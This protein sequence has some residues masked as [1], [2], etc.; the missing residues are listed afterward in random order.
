MKNKGLETWLY[1][2]LGVAAMFG[3]IVIVNALAS[4]FNKRVDLTAERAYTLSAGTRAIL[5]KLDTPIQIRFYSTRGIHELTFY[6]T[7]SIKDQNAQEVWRPEQ[8]QEL[9]N[10]LH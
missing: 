5:S 2:S 4:S 8:I 3:I 10:F 9:E 1:S 6:K 7:G